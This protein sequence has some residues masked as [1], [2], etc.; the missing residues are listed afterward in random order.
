M[1]V[2]ARSETIV[3]A[4]HSTPLP[5][6][7]RKLSRYAIGCAAAGAAWRSRLTAAAAAAPSL[8]STLSPIDVV[9][10]AIAVIVGIAVPQD[11]VATAGH[12]L[13]DQRLLGEAGIDQIVARAGEGD[14]GRA[15]DRLLDDL[16]TA[17]QRIFRRR[18]PAHA[19]VDEAEVELRVVGIA[20]WPAAALI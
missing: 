13:L 10:V 15:V 19:A 11:A 5:E 3:W 18:Q 20:D 1:S 12:R 17:G 7:I 6:P 16:G 8:S 9:L 4:V 2:S 14:R